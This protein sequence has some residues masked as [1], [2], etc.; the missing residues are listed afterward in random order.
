MKI[1]LNW[2]KEDTNKPVGIFFE[3]CLSKDEAKTL[4]ESLNFEKLIDAN[5]ADRIIIFSGLIGEEKAKWVNSRFETEILLKHQKNGLENWIETKPDVK[6]KWRKEIKMKIS[7]LDSFLDTE[8][9]NAFLTELAELSLGIGVTR[10]E[11]MIITNL[12]KDVDQA[13]L[14]MENGGS[15]AAYEQAREKIEKYIELLKQD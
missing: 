3:E 7:E 2:N 9:L 15:V 12:C 4:K 13:K 10:E 14:S 5:R 8:E 6:P 11:A 1:S